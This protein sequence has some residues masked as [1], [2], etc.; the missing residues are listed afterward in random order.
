VANALVTNCFYRFGIPRELHSDQ[1]RDF[2]SRLLQE[3]VQRMGVSKTRATPLH[4]Q[5]DGMVDRYIRTTEEDL[6]PTRGTET[7]CC[8]LST[9]LSGIHAR[10]HRLH[11]SKLVIRKRAP[12]AQRSTAR[13][14]SRQG[15]VNTRACGKFVGPSARHP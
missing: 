1:G 9:G 2:E 10:Y 12:T 14:T 4:P 8:P 7:P 13:D 6:H 11:P 3:I 5:S 15:A